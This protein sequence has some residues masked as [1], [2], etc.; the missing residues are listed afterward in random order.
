MFKD[1]IPQFVKGRILKTE[2]L[3][4]LRDYP[5]HACEL[6]LQDWSDGIVAGAAVRAEGE[7]LVIQK[8]IIKYRDRLYMLTSDVS[9][10]YQATGRETVIKIRFEDADQSRDYTEYRTEVVLDDEV[11]LLP[12]EMELGLAERNIREQIVCRRY[13]SAA[14]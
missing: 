8:G 10:P 9:I 1:H 6:F 3:E 2:M 12:N 14:C 11:R 5:R 4:S 7:H 13:V